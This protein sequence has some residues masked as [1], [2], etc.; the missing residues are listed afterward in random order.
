MSYLQSLDMPYWILS[1]AFEPGGD[2]SH[3]GDIGMINACLHERARRGL[4]SF[5]I[6][7]VDGIDAPCQ[8]L[9]LHELDA[10]SAAIEARLGLRVPP[11][12]ATPA[13]KVARFIKAKA[14]EAEAARQPPPP[15][16]DIFEDFL[17]KRAKQRKRGRR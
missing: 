6:G 10:L 4:P 9:A 13:H 15:R 14:A 1:G 3:L 12:P 2:V 11:M 7:Y 8:R 17:S 16:C 5:V